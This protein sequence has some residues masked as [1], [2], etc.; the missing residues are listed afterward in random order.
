MIE[1]MKNVYLSFLLT[2]VTISLTIAQNSSDELPY[3]EISTPTESYSV[4]AV[5][6]RMV[7]G[8]GFRYYWA[9]EG[10][11]CNSNRVKREEL[12]PKQLIIFWAFPD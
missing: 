4:G 9:T 3:R 12:R 7:D 10:L 6:A 8:L 1:T 11:T 5:A 2:M